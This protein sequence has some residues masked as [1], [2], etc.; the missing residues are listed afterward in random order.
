MKFQA[1]TILGNPAPRLKLP[2]PQAGQVA[3]VGKPHVLSGDWNHFYPWP[4]PPKCLAGERQ[5]HGMERAVNA[6]FSGLPAF[7]QQEDPSSFDLSSLST[8][9]CRVFG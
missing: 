5:W 8:G 7:L 1:F 4:W 3:G 9:P 6:V 2:G